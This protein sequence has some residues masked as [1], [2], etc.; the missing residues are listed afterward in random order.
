MGL[1]AALSVEKSAQERD[2]D[3]K[4]HVDWDRGLGHVFEV[5]SPT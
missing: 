5:G 1:I 2:T 3:A 4:E